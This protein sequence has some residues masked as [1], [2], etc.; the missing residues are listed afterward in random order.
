MKNPAVS[1]N[2]N[3][4]YSKNMNFLFFYFWASKHVL[5]WVDMTD[6]TSTDIL[7]NSSKHPH[8]PD[9]HNPI[10]IWA[11]ESLFIWS[12]QLKTMTGNPTALPK[13][14]V[15]YV[16]PVPAGPAGAPPIT[17]LSACVRVI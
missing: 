5:T 16:F 10:N 13:S 6:N 1:S 9:W 12:E 8:A 4:P 15:V 17:K 14:L 3:S 7:L 2:D 11:I